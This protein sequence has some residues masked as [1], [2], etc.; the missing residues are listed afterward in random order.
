M[1]AHP[2]LITPRWVRRSTVAFRAARPP[3]RLPVGTV[4]PHVTTGHR[5]HD[6]RARRLARN[7]AFRRETNE[8]I[9]RET[10]GWHERVFDCICECSR[11][12]CMARVRVTT[13]EYEHVRASGDHFVVAR[14]HD[15]PSLEVV[16][17]SS[18]RYVVVEKRGV[19][20]EVARSTDPR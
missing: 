2:G 9:E 3:P 20:G 17:E 13:A 7:E 11:A 15:D 8:V 18:D 12:G 6:D 19:A 16:V 4:P 14:G 1:Q 5:D 10:I